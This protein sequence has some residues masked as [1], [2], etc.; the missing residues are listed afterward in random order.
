MPVSQPLA[1]ERETQ[2]EPTAIETAPR[3]IATAPADSDFAQP[4]SRW[5]RLLVP[6]LA[7]CF[8]VATIVWAFFTGR[9]WGDLLLDGD[10]G[11]H[12]RVGEYILDH[13]A[14]PSVDLFSFSKAGQPWFAWEWLSDVVYGLLFRGGGMKGVVLFSGLVIAG[15]TMVLFRHMLWRGAN[16]FIALFLTLIAAG[17]ASIHYHAR[18][19]ILTLLLLGV[20]MW[21]LER[22]RR[23]P[24]RSLWLLVP[25]TVVWTNLHGGFLALIALTGLLAAGLAVENLLRGSRD[26]ALPKRYAL[27]AVLCGA[28][29]FVNPYGARLH[30]HIASYLR[31]DWI[32]NAIQEFQSPQFRSESALQFEGLLIAGLMTAG[33]MLLRKEV[34][35]PLWIGYL[36]HQALSS[37]RHILLYTVVATPLIA[38]ELTQLWQFWAGGRPRWSVP[39]ILDSIARDL[40]PGLCRFSVWTA[41]FVGALISLR[42]PIRWPDNF[43]ATHFPVGMVE[44]YRAQL[45]AQRVLTMDQWGDYLIFRS[46]P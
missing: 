31:S 39:A 24:G 35:G 6:S 1:G 22:D 40:R 41:V 32:R 21:V 28:A 3:A 16:A 12:I 26:W 34:V 33:L 2:V 45:A 42:E 38:S 46:Y 4:A 5:G 11:W 18:P 7:D 30:L 19:H 25:L 29:S 43:P 10:T 8:L 14:V 13:G 17:A 36:A 44:K 15:W 37:Q 27:L 23:N 9:G 20:S